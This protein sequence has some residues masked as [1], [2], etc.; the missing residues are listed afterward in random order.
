MAVANISPYGIFTGLGANGL[1][2]AGGL[3]FTYLAGT[4]TK[5]NT[6][7]SASE[8]TANPNPVVM[9][10]AGQAQVWLDSATTYKFVFSPANDTD[11]PT[12]PF[13]TT[14]NIAPAV[15]PVTSVNGRTGAVTIT[16]GDVTGALTYTPVNPAADTTFTAGVQT[17]PVV[18]A[19]SAAN[20]TANCTLSNVFATTLTG[21]VTAPPTISNPG[22]GQTI[23]W[24][25]TQ[26]G[27]GSRLITGQWP[28]SFKWP[29]GT[30]GVLSTAANAVDLLVATYRATTSS[31]YANLL[32]AFS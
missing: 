28:T 2:V 20:M 17:T 7:T 13:W 30:K 9:N 1:P 14:D 10:A 16:S 32:K 27:T 21:N 4:T 11:P 12:N 22:D 19:F 26:D 24:F 29:G 18:V 8:A 5:T 3:L 25:I 15:S 6:Y 23:N 31:W